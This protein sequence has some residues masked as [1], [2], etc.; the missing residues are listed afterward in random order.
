[1]LHYHVD[2][3]L[4]RR[5]CL[6]L[7][8]WGFRRDRN[9]TRLT[10]KLGS[11]REAS[12]L[13][14][15]VEHGQRRDDVKTLFSDVSGAEES[16]FFLFAGLGQK[17]I[18]HARL[19]WE[20]DGKEVL[21]TPIDFCGGEKR[22]TINIIKQYLLLLVKALKLIQSTGLTSLVHKVRVYFSARPNSTHDAEWNA[23]YA[24][25]RG[26]PLTVVIDHDMGGGKYL[27]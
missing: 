12:E 24:R 7:M 6:L 19:E 14:I 1:M 26:R 15:E 4:V 5:N 13:E 11:D 23:L 8:G 3:I 25:L 16:G 10:L 22:T 2:S 21:E 17:N 9:V 18:T 27:P 20:F